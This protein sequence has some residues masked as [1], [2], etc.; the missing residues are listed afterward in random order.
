MIK[1]GGGR[2]S[3]CCKY[4]WQKKREKQGEKAILNEEYWKI[5]HEYIKETTR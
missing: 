5:K 2:E 1:R 4:S 3:L